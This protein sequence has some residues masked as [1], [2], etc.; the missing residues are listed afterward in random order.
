MPPWKPTPGYG[1]FAGERDLSEGEISVIRRWIAGGELEGDPDDLPPVPVWTSGWEL[2]QPDLV[3]PMPAAYTLRA[4][5]ADVF[6]N[7]AIPLPVDSTRYVRAVEFKPGNARIVHH[8]TMMIYRTV[9][10]RKNVGRE[11]KSTRLNSRPC[12]NSYPVS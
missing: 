5:G 12:W 4:D 3:A 6:R 11:R 8:A 7:F 1:R 9:A 2:G 10:A